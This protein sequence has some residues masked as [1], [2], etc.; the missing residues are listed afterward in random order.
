MPEP[1]GSALPPL[2]DAATVNE[3]WC[4]APTV[5]LGNSAQP[6]ALDVDDSWFVGAPASAPS[7]D[8]TQVAPLP[9]GGHLVIISLVRK[10]S[11][12]IAIEVAAVLD[13]EGFRVTLT[14]RDLHRPVIERPATD[15]PPAGFARAAS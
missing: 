5:P 7:G 3:I 13:G 15:P 6:Y 8:A 9:E 14:H 2:A 1:S 12:A 11:A 10:S 4:R